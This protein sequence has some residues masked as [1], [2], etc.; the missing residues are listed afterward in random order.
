MPDWIIHLAFAYL[1]AKLFKIREIFLI[2]LG[3]LIPDISRIVSTME[4]AHI[5]P[6]IYYSLM[7]PLHSP[8]LVIIIAIAISLL[9]KNPLKSFS[10]IILGSFTHFLLDQIQKNYY[11][12]KPL[13]YPLSYKPFQSLGLFWPDSTFAVILMIIGFFILLY[14]IFDKKKKT[15]KFTFKKIHLVIIFLLIY[16]ITPLITFNNFSAT[17][18]Y[19]N[20]FENGKEKEI[21]F[22][23]SYIK[24]ENPL[25]IEE[26]GYE[27]EI[28]NE[29]DVV[30]GNWISAI[31][32]KIDDK[33]YIKEFHKHN[34]YLKVISSL[35]GLM[36]FFIIFLKNPKKY[37]SIS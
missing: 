13:L 22:S 34:R 3:A 24:S 33:V 23:Y 14:A 1:T 26:M 2:L 10:Y 32:E 16:I 29:I 31:A 37:K 9:F 17:N 20:Q 36:M 6:N 8:F 19:T 28:I 7:A 15:I 21:Y 27:F 5:A 12:G 25:I 30:K 35:I 11:V 18:D 4:L